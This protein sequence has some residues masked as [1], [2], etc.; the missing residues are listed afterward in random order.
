M[1]NAMVDFDYARPKSVREAVALLTNEPE[2]MALAGGQSLIPTLKQRLARPTLLVDVQDID[3]MRGIAVSDTHV[4][5]GA[6]TRHAEVAVDAHIAEALP[7]LAHMAY[8]IAHPQVRHMGTM[9]GS[10]AH[11][12]PG[13]DYPA[14]VLGLGATIHTDRRR[15]AADAFFT[16]LFAT[17]LE[18]GEL[19]L[20]IEYPRHHRSGY[21]KIAHPASGLVNTGAWVTRLDDGVRVVINGAAPCV[22]RHQELERLLAARFDPASLDGFRQPSEGL[23]ADM[24]A[25]AEYR[26]QLVTVTVKRALAM[27]L[28]H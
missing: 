4:V 8:G 21:C 24:H 16:G 6:M 9:G 14:A 10:V 3:E 23:N 7:A 17:A 18:P 26:A 15:I 13:A 22:F 27:A 12:D 28:S 5:V 25:S 2:A 11:N 1:S 19:V 20:R